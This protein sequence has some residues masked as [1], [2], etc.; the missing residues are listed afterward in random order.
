MVIPRLCARKNART[1]RFSYSRSGY[2]LA[3]AHEPV[4]REREH[5]RREATSEP[6]AA[7][8]TLTGESSRGV[9]Q[10]IASGRPSLM[11]FALTGIVAMAIWAVAALVAAVLFLVIWLA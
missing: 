11:P 9:E 2:P 7:D 1:R 6:E 8:D 5:E 10:E 3:M 4:T